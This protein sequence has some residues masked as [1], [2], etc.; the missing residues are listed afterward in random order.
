MS[1]SV[2]LGS[3]FEVNKEDLPESGTLKL[4]EAKHCPSLPSHGIVYG[5]LLDGKQK[6]RFSLP[7][8]CDA[9]VDSRVSGLVDLPEILIP[10][11][12]SK[13][14]SEEPEELFK[15]WIQT[16]LELRQ[17]SINKGVSAEL[18]PATLEVIPIKWPV[19]YEWLEE[20]SKREDP[21]YDPI[22]EIAENS[23]GTVDRL[24]SYPRRILRRE[25]ERVPL[26]QLEEIDEACMRW[27]VRQPGRNLAERAGSQ[28]TLLGI[29]RRDNFDTLENRVLRDFG[30]RAS[31]EA[32]EYGTR[33]AFYSESGRR[34]MVQRFG[35][36]LTDA[37]SAS[38]IVKASKLQFLPEPNFVLQFD[39]NY[40]SIWKWYLMLIRKKEQTD[41]AR[42][43]RSRLWADR[44][45]LLLSHAFQESTE[46]EVHPNLNLWLR[47]EQDDGVWTGEWEMP[48]F[49]NK[50]R[51]RFAHFVTP[52][53]PRQYRSLLNGK[54]GDLFGTIGASSALL[55]WTAGSKEPEK[56]WFFV[57]EPR[58]FKDWGPLKKELERLEDII[59]KFSHGTF[60][61]IIV[62][63]GDKVV[64]EPLGN[65]AGGLRTITMP[66]ALRN[67]KKEQ[68]AEL[69]AYLFPEK[70]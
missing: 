21:P 10:P 47:S 22:V 64:S 11:G 45:R 24:L 37:Q 52:D 51:D 26:G 1:L 35:R 17:R 70:W 65:S 53:V 48:P 33:H 40:R 55:V 49:V 63:P 56:A 54:F 27:M 34:L 38:E 42:M 30:D 14:P 29:V 66:S 7:I 2:S 58:R 20:E 50:K 16:F 41:N 3:T 15:D 5:D 28:Q 32:L 43:W 44:C 46:L 6:K 23:W 57:T 31:G 62:S 9:Q 8:W 18:K 59:T 13:E 25:R 36:K 39:R 4:L 69:V 60:E 12:E 19:A 61:I 67:W 68:R